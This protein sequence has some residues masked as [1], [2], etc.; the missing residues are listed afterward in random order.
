[1]Q[2]GSETGLTRRVLLR[3]SL[4]FCAGGLP[5]LMACDG[6]VGQSGEQTAS[7]GCGDLAGLSTSDRALRDSLQYVDQSP[8]GSDQ[9]CRHCQFFQAPAEGVCGTCTA[10]KGP[11]HPEGHCSIWS[12]YPKAT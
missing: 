4:G 8:H 3:N 7:T 6:S 1:M 5:L 12:P 11:I 2:A 9:R 10:V